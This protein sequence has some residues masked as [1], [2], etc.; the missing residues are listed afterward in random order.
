MPS[1]HPLPPNHQLPE[2]EP[3]VL[4]LAHELADFRLVR[5]HWTK[6]FLH[7]FAADDLVHQLMERILTQI[8]ADGYVVREYYELPYSADPAPV[9][10]ATKQEIYDALRRLDRIVFGFEMPVR[11]EYTP[12]ALLDGTHKRHFGNDGTCWTIRFNPVLNNYLRNVAQLLYVL[13]L[14]SPPRVAPKSA[15]RPDRHSTLEEL[16]APTV[17]RRKA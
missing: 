12:R 16:L 5:T 4:G 14:P 8:R 10:G 13:P 15:S 9:D 3:F 1:P 17:R 11:Q 2:G 6:N 7:Q